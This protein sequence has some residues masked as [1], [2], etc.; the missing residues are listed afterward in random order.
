MDTV[1]KFADESI[2]ELGEY[3]NDLG[4][5]ATIERNEDGGAYYATF[6]MADIA[7]IANAIK[8]VPDSYINEQGNGITQQGIAYL[9]PLISGEVSPKYENGLPVHVKI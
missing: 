9:L 7:G 1:Y 3:G 2:K 5:M 4:V 8:T 6:G